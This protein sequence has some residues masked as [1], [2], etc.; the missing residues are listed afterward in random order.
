MV[1]IGDGVGLPHEIADLDVGHADAA[2]DR[3]ADRAVAEL[4]LQI[5]ELRA[6]SNSAVAFETLTWVCALLS[7][8]IG[9]AF[10]ADKVGVALDVALAPARTCASRAVD[11]GL[12]ALHVGLDRAAVER[13]QHVALLDARAVV[14]NERR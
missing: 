12:D 10:L 2:G 1:A 4:H 8:T 11:H 7:V 14:G 13:E 5:L 3:R 6:G 9:V